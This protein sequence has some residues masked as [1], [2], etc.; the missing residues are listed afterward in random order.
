MRLRDYPLCGR[1]ESD[2]WQDVFL[3]V[4]S[5][6]GNE[7]KEQTEKMGKITLGFSGPAAAKRFIAKVKQLPYVT[8]ATDYS[9]GGSKSN[10]MVCGDFTPER[11]EYIKSLKKY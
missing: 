5:F 4:L 6:R 10:V 2:T 11:E 7:Q 9:R 3:R 1:L 8:Y